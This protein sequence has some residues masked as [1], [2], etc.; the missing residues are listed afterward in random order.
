VGRQ[1]SLLRLAPHPCDHARAEEWRD[2]PAR[3]QR[4]KVLVQYADGRMTPIQNAEVN[5]SNIS[6][7]SRVNFGPLFTLAGKVTDA[8]QRHGAGAERWWARAQSPQAAMFPCAA[9]RPA[10]YAAR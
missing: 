9:C 8:P 6:A 7:V 2:G 5:D 3:S 10:R 1:W 4:T